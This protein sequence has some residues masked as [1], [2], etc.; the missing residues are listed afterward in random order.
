MLNVLEDDVTPFPLDLSSP[1]VKIATN[2]L[3]LNYPKD[4]LLHAHLIKCEK[5]LKKVLSIQNFS[6]IDWALRTSIITSI[7]KYLHV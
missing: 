7:P 1:Y 4:V 6:S 2:Q 3:I 5:Y